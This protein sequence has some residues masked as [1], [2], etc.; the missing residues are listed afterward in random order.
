MR[1]RAKGRLPLISVAIVDGAAVGGG[2]ELA[3]CCDFRVAGPESVIRFVQ[4]KVRACR[5]LLFGFG[6]TAHFTS[7][8]RSTSDVDCPG[9]SLQ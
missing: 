1:V 7:P 8:L 4:A 2:A 6:G 3:T 9:K 5:S